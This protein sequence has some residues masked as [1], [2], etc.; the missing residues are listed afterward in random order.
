[1]FSQAAQD[2][3]ART[4]IDV[5]YNPVNPNEVLLGVED[6]AVAYSNDGAST[7]VILQVAPAANDRQSPVH[8]AYASATPGLVYASIDRNDGEVWRSNNGGLNWALAGT[9]HQGPAGGVHSAI[10]VD[11]LDSNRVVVGGVDIWL[12]L[13][14]AATFHRISDWSQWPASLH[15]DQQVI[16]SDPGYGR[17]GNARV[18]FANDGGLYKAEN[19]ASVTPTTGRTNLDNGLGI[20]QFWGGAA[21]TAEGGPLLGGLQDSG[22]S[23]F[24][25]QW[26]RWFGGDGGMTWID[27][28]NPAIMYGE[29]VNAAVVRTLNGAA[30]GQ[31]FCEGA[32]QQPVMA[33]G[34]V[35]SPC[36][37]VRRT[38]SGSAT[39]TESFTFR[40]MPCPRCRP[41]D[42]SPDFRRD[43]SPGSC[44]TNRYQA[45]FMWQWAAL[46][47]ATCMR[48]TMVARPGRASATRCPQRRSIRSRS[49]LET[50]NG[51]TQALKSGSSHRRT[52]D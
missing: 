3:F 52:W 29:Y 47:R 4:V 5:K 22:T 14:G 46:P 2:G 7:F 11:P 1:V 34:S 8:L 25:T 23:V 36:S 20:A 44:S 32:R 19:F 17:N 42:H 12:S 24:R 39:T 10:W 16:Y 49:I 48:R 50:D 35:P 21:S 13:D 28:A 9:P 38:S 27:Q 51:F 45:A 37:R 31:F 6:G 33:T 43:T 15:A 30:T 41:G 26:E 40:T 18:Y